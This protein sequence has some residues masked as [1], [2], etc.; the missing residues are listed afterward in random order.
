VIEQYR[1]VNS[2]NTSYVS[3]TMFFFLLVLCKLCFRDYVFLSSRF[4]QVMF[5]FFHV[6]FSR[7]MHF[8]LLI[9]GSYVSVCSCQMMQL[10]I[11]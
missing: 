11:V 7:F 4:M 10:E 3:E 8:V 9:F 2:F 5:Q 6:E 1:I